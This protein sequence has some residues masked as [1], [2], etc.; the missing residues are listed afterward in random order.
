MRIMVLTVADCPNAP[1]VRERITAALGGREAVVELCEVH[2][3]A[4]AG[5]RGMT[6]SPTVLIDGIDPFAPEGAVPSVSCRLYRSADGTVDGAPDLADLRRALAAAGLSEVAEEACCESDD[7]LDPVGR[8]SRGRRAPAARGLRAVHQAVLRHFAAA[9][10]D[11]LRPVAAAHGRTV[12]A[13]PAELA[14]EDFLTLDEAGSI[15]AAYPFSA[16]PT[17][18]RVR[19]GDVEVWSMCAIDALGIPAMLGRDGVI[20]STD[21]V[22]GEAVS[23]TATSG[24]TVWEPPRAVVFIGRRPGSG[25]A[26]AVCCDA[27]NFFTSRASASTWARA[28]PGTPVRIIEQARA[29]EIAAQT[30]GPLLA[31]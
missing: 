25:P 1:V 18:H 9:G 31:D 23:V 6:G 30:F 28:H 7:G 2:D 13:V 26:A 17:R 5:A 4:E 12:H 24:T 15:Q 19:V 22:T 8:G 27:L 20:S 21:P 14:R 10:A 16:V 29:E 11:V 3:E